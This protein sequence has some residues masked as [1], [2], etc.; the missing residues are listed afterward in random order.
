MRAFILYANP[1]ATCFGAAL[2][3]QVVTTLRSRGYEIDDCDLYVESFDPMKEQERVEYHDATL[4]MARVAV[5]ANR[6]LAA[7]ALVLVYPVWNEG[8]PAILK[9]FFDRVFIPGVSFRIG[10]EGAATP[11]LQKL[12]NL[13][14]VCTYGANCAATPNLQKL[15]NLA[16][17]CTYGA[18]RMSTFL[19]DPPR[20]VVNG[21]STRSWQQSTLTVDSIPR[22]QRRSP[23]S[24]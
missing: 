14:A 7:D 22:S 15:K 13:A 9:G 5:Y 11:N 2:H 12:K 1:V 4:N 21:T 23:T 24:S 6:L 17:V 20:R 3:K 19:G 8:F 10:P 16:A 18:N